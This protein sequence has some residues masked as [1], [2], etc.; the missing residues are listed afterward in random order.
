MNKVKITTFIQHLLSSICLII[1]VFLLTTCGKVK[2]K[3]WIVADV[4]VMNE[5]NNLPIANE[6]IKLF[7]LIN[8]L[9]GEAQE[10][11]LVLGKSDENGLLH[12]EHRVNKNMLGFEIGVLTSNQY[13][14]VYYR[15]EPV[16]VKK[17]NHIVFNL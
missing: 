3:K 17:K 13:G 10:A 6:E 4:F 9:P 14:S 2:S 7:Y 16:Y 12:V 1:S 5:E 8:P 11:S 15:T